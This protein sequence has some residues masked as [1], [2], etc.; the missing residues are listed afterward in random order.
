MQRKENNDYLKLMLLHMAMGG[1]VFLFRPLSVIYAA[2]ILICGCY[3][4]VKNRNTHNEVLFWAA[5]LVAAEVFL[6]MTKGNI[7]NEFAKYGVIIF[8]LLGIYFSG[9]SKKAIPYGIYLLLLIPGI[10][11]GTLSLNFETDIRKAIVFNLLGPICLAISSIYNANKKVTFSDFEKI[12]RWMA[13]PIGA[14]VVYLFLFNPNVR[15]VVTGTDSNSATS[16]GFGPNQVSTILGLGMF[17]AFVRLLFFSKNIFLICFN[18]FF[19]LVLSYRG[20]ITFSRGGVYTGIM[21]IVMLLIATY[22][23]ISLKGKFKVNL[24]AVCLV[25]FG[26]GVFTYSISQTGGMV[27]NR[28]KGED[29]LGREKVS[30]FSGREELAAVELEMFMDNPIAGVGV[31]KNKEYREQLTGI[32]AASHNEITRM[33]AEHGILGIVCLLILIITPL[34]LYFDN[35]QHIFLLSFY[36]FWFLTINHASMRVAAPAFIYS[37]AL[38]KVI[39]VEKPAVHRE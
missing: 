17:L 9:I 6:R 13:Y 1:V 39:L 38:L 37:L 12:T 3:Y 5:Y 28:Y 22:P 18:A 8:S 2:L 26:I 27:L 11:I 25:V 7:G 24:L 10:I 36:F 23:Y 19:L 15:D 33:L 21:M 20:I 31:G 29:A 35:R 4:I 16:G 30:K 14:M 32:S 34:L